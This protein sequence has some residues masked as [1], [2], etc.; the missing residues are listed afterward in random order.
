MREYVAL[1]P[2]ISAEDARVWVARSL[3]YAASLPP[4][5][6]KKAKTRSG[7]AADLK[8]KT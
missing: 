2:T 1:P 3:D 4:K 7:K 5:P 8:K 6:A